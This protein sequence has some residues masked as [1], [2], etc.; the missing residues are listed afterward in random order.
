MDRQS[1]R[2]EAEIREALAAAEGSDAAGGTHVSPPLI[3]DDDAVG[4][5]DASSLDDVEVTG[6][7]DDG[8]L[9]DTAATSDALV[10]LGS[11]GAGEGIEDVRA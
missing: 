6:R 2:D 10:D 7:E 9:S 8:I 11:V 1:L 5:T 3:G 4:G